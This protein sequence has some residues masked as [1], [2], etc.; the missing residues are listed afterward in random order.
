MKVYVVMDWIPFE[1]RE[2]RAVCESE[3][4]AKLWVI[5]NRHAVVGEAEIE[6]CEVVM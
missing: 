2:L 5:Q 1:G 3:S 4:R 6:E